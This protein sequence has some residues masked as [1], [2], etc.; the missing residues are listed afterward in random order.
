M[1]PYKEMYFCLFHVLTDCIERMQ[2]AQQRAETLFMQAE[3]DAGESAHVETEQASPSPG[4]GR[5]SA[6]ACR[7][8]EKGL[9]TAAVSCIITQR[10]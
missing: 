2:Q 5:A 10:E 8:V 4:K 1:E 6:G 7:M 3:P 9:H